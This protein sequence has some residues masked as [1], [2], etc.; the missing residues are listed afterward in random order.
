M[1]AIVA[2][3]V[4]LNACLIPISW[5]SLPMLTF[6][7]FLITYTP[8]VLSRVTPSAP[9]VLETITPTDKARDSP[10]ITPL[11]DDPYMLVRQ[12]YTPIATN[13]ESEPLED[14]I[15]TKETQPLSPKA[16]PLSPDCTLASPNYTLDT[17]YSDEDSKPMEVSETRTASP[18]GST[19]PLSP[20]HLL[21]Y[22]SHTSTPSRAFYYHSTVR[23]AMRT[24]PTLSPGISAKVIEAMALSPP[25]FHKRYRSSYETPSS[26][27]SPA[28]SPTLPIR[29]RY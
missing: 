14:L 19:L 23:M 27:A 15:E 26:S 8:T 21:A 10:V 24:Q 6:H 11:H 28:S 1:I 22:T 18:S 9:T 29:K 5:S 3:F 25:S 2:L 7:V 20:D 4:T 12:A 17:S 16:A 13:I